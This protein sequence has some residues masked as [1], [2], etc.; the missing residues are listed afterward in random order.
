MTETCLPQHLRQGE[1]RANI[2]MDAL[3]TQVPLR[4]EFNALA[5]HFCHIVA[6]SGASGAGKSTIITLI[7]RKM[8]EA[9]SKQAP[10]K[11]GGLQGT[12]YDN[13]ILVIGT[14]YNTNHP[15]PGTDR[16]PP[17]VAPELLQLLQHP[18]SPL[19]TILFEGNGMKSL[20]KS[21]LD[22]CVIGSR[23]QTARRSL[24]NVFCSSVQTLGRASKHTT[25]SPP[26][27]SNSLSKSLCQ[28]ELLLGALQGLSREL[29]TAQCG[30]K[31]R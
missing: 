26:I 10:W 19:R 3:S 9:Y 13:A 17:T 21:I 2:C 16:L 29:H 27:P 11:R 30:G 4:L 20:T 8:E 18:P 22:E 5:T 25:P 31:P 14:Y 7:V 23:V 1:L 28:Q 12:L 15:T 6:I 24:M